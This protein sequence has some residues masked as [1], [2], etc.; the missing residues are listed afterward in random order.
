MI[1][2]LSLSLLETAI[3]EPSRPRGTDVCVV[4]CGSCFSFWAAWPLSS[5]RETGRGGVCTF[6][7]A[8]LLASRAQTC[9]D[10]GL[11]ACGSLSELPTQT[12]AVDEPGR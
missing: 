11:N 12:G 10:T 5:L 3:S 1:W 8:V 7:S 2:S 4:Y 9:K 6:F